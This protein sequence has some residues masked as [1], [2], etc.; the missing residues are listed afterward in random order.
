MVVGTE[1]FFNNWLMNILINIGV[2]LFISTYTQKNYLYNVNIYT[3][4]Y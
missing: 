4:M 3:W 2:S 1:Y